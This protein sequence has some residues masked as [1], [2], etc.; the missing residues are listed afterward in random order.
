MVDIEKVFTEKELEAASELADLTRQIKKLEDKKKKLSEDL[1]QLMIDKDISEFNHDSNSF[2]LVVT[3]KVT[4]PAKTKAELLQKLIESG[5]KNLIKTVIEPDAEG[6][7]AEANASLIS[8]DF[9]NKYVK[10]TEVR[11]LRIN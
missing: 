8:W 1:K 3:E 7:L 10:V 2:S 11:T 6:I 9:C 5:K 4:A